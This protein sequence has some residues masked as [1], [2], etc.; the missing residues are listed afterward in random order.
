MCNAENK[1]PISFVKRTI[2]LK[3]VK[4]HIPIFLRDVLP[5]S[6]RYQAILYAG[7]KSDCL[8]TKNTL[9]RFKKPTYLK[10]FK[11]AATM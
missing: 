3:S 2:F 7:F 10:C 5:R 1:H 6:S 8:K 11:V 9:N 4:I